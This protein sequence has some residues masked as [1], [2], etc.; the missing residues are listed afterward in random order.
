MSDRIAQDQIARLE[1]SVAA[2]PGAAEFPAL[3]AALHRTGRIADAERVAR[4]GLEHKPGRLEGS[5]LLALTLLDQGRVED[6][7]T[8]LAEAAAIGLAEPSPRS[9][10]FP[11]FA[12]SLGAEGSEF[13]DDVTD[14][15]LESAFDAARPV[16]DELVDA[17]R[18]V[19]VAIRDAELDQPEALGTVAADP[20][21]ATQTMADLLERQGDGAGA[22]RIRE[23]LEAMEDGPS[24]SPVG[25]TSG[26]RILSTLESWLDNLRSATR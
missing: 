18:V 19:E 1:A 24:P 15:E 12:P 3:V 16:A 6:A 25:S 9:A 23:S 7:R 4:R 17:N 5:V 14:G 13:G 2:D 22:S 10:E 20:L 21:F 11:D 26:D 8:V